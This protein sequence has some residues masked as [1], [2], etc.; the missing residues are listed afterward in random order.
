MKK[1]EKKFLN[2]E[3]FSNSSSILN[4]Y[5]TVVLDYDFLTF[6]AQK[7]FEDSFIRIIS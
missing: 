3:T 2:A 4:Y 6:E 5:S 1:K 7:Y